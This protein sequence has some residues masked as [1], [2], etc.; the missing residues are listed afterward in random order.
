MK[1]AIKLNYQIAKDYLY[2]D[3]IYFL[4]VLDYIDE[5]YN[6]KKKMDWFKIK[7]DEKFSNPNK[8]LKRIIKKLK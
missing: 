4:E 2:F 7:G 3:D 8:M 1:S 5:K 6:L